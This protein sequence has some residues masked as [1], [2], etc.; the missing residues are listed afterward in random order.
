MKRT[1]E[2]KHWNTTTYSGE[3]RVGENPAM[4]PSSLA[5]DFGPLSNEEINVR[6]WETLSWP[7][8]PN[9][10]IR[11]MMWPASLDPLP[12]TYIVSLSQRQGVQLENLYA[13][14]H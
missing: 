14:N 7:P 5:L 4:P 2:H 8:K 6:Y 11:H 10:W 1:A 3:S 12:T 9:I 13:S